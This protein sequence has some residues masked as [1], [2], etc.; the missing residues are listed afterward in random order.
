MILRNR[1]LAAGLD[2]GAT[3]HIFA[4]MP[5]V[6]RELRRR[7]R[8]EQSAPSF[9]PCLPRPADKPPAGPG[10]IH[11]SPYRGGRSAHWLKIKNRAALGGKAR[12][13]RGL[14][15]IDGRSGTLYQQLSVLLA[16]VPNFGAPGELSPE[17]ETWLARAYALVKAGG[18]DAQDTVDMKQMGGRSV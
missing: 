15:L 2:S 5:S 10:W 13:G 16:S 6:V 1:P 8:V 17:D 7:V 3:V 14:E 9:E 12:S 18:G 11:G 4:G